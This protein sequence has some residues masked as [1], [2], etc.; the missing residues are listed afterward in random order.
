MKVALDR[1]L[2]AAARGADHREAVRAAAEALAGNPWEVV[3]KAGALAR[4]VR[5]VAE[6]DLGVT[7]DLYVTTPDGRN[8]IAVVQ[9]GQPFPAFDGHGRRLRG[10]FDT[11]MDLARRVVRSAARSVEGHATSG[12][13]PACGTGSFLVALHEQGVRD[14]YGSDLDETA[15]AVASV[16]VPSAKLSVADAL[17]HGPEVD[18]VVG[19]PPFVP[20]EHQDKDLRQLLRRRFPWLRGRFDLV[21]P[22]AATAVDRVRPGGAAGLV[23]PFPALVQPYGT[24]LRRRWLERHRVATLVGPMPF[25]GASVEVGVIILQADR[26]PADLPSGIAPDELLRLENAPLDPALAPGDVDLVE[27]VRRH[28]VPLGDLA[29][30]DTGLVAHGEGHGKAAL[31]HDLP[32]PGRVPYADAR[33]FFAGER[34]W[35]E[36]APHKM[37]RPKSPALFEPPKVVVQRLRGRGPVRAAVDRAGTYVGHT[38]TVIVPRDPRLDV[39]RICALVTSPIVDALVRIERGQR[40]DLYPRDV[41]GIPVPRAWLEDPRAPLERAF[42]LN[43]LHVQRLMSMGPR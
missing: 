3:A 31:I 14:I 20:P 18:L 28:T 23:V 38:C 8:A 39:D 5:R 41:M 37:H 9:Q 7:A 6:R 33:Q 21:V 36:Y 30:I 25:P 10:A 15:L 35:L 29:W 11:P 24:T 17:S 34:K 26:G 40:L 13:D 22:F 12:L 42:G 4:A 43:E 27:V 19:N 16:A 32:G 2:Y 1:Y